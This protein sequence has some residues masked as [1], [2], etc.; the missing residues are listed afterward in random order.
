MSAQALRNNIKTHDDNTSDIA[1]D[2]QQ[3]ILKLVNDYGYT[4]YLL[5]ELCGVWAATISEWK[6]HGVDPRFRYGF[7]I[8]MTLKA[9]MNNDAEFNKLLSGCS[10]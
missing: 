6:N 1:F 7:V 3:A 9:E 8:M 5:G 4:N 10:L 2:V